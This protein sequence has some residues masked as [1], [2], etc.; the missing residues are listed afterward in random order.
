MRSY[1]TFVVLALVLGTA[2][3]LHAQEHKIEMYAE[4]RRS[5]VTNEWWLP[6]D[7]LKSC[8]RWDPLHEKVPLPPDRAAKIAA[9]W[10][11]KREGFKVTEIEDI[12]IGTFHSDAKEF[13]HVFYYRF[14]YSP[15]QFDFAS[16]IVL[17][18]GTVVEPSPLKKRE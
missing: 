17:M 7:R 13:H 8:P 14:L 2:T 1:L 16:C 18:D 3:K 10:I 15:R 4:V 6:V 12:Q 5:G 9:E 11:E